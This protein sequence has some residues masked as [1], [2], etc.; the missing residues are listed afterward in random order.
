LGTCRLMM[1]ASAQ[2]RLESRAH[3]LLPQLPTENV[4]LHTFGFTVGQQSWFSGESELYASC[5]KL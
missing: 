1:A 3:I 4:V 2:M 5:N